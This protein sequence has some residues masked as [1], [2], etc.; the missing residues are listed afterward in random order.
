MQACCTD[1]YCILT[2]S[3]RR[4]PQTPVLK[5][6]ENESAHQP[7]VNR[8]V[9]SRDFLMGC[10]C[11]AP[12]PVIKSKARTEQAAPHSACAAAAEANKR[13]KQTHLAAGSKAEQAQK[14]NTESAAKKGSGKDAQVSV[15]AKKGAA[16]AKKK[17][18]RSVDD[19]TPRRFT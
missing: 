7:Q 17:K 2:V 1:C 18:K 4:V 16:A 15:K 8:V 6:P 9:Q 11:A 10:V 13:K 12:A 3:A 19:D 5:Y 14:K